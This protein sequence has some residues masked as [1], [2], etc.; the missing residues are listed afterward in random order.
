MLIVFRLAYRRGWN[1]DNEGPRAVAK[2][3]ELCI[4]L[5][6]YLNLTLM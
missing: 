6:L 2:T 1:T 5:A 3:A 4:P